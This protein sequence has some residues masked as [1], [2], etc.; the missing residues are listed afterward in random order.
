MFANRHLLNFKV[1]CTSRAYFVKKMACDL[2]YIGNSYLQITLCNLYIIYLLK[3]NYVF[4][5]VI[6]KY[7]E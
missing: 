4:I 6:N 5:T 1:K 3:D 7:T 2:L